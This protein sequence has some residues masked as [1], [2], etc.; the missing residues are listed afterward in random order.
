MLEYFH[1]KGL[2]MYLK[3][4]RHPDL[5]W[6]LLEPEILVDIII[7][8][9]TPPPE[10]TQRKGMRHDWNLLQTKGM[11]TKP[12]LSRTISNV[13]ENIEA[14]TAFLEE[15][16]L[17]CPL[18]NTEVPTCRP[19]ACE[20]THFVPSLLP[21]SA[22]GN[23]PVWHDDD[24]DKEFYVFFTDSFQIPCFIICCPVHTNSAKCCFQ[25]AKLFC[26]EMLASSL[27][28]LGHLTDS[29]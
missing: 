17:I 4:S 3:N 6:V 21:M 22:D 7:Q 27:W 8:L 9:V 16:D 10:N 25:M 14:M 28:M 26:T 5:S 12:L 18:V 1:E 15:Y 11:L 20:P 24:S 29:N 2:V 19:K 23:V 13:K